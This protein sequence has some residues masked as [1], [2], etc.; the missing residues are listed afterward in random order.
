MRHNL[1]DP[2]HSLE[3]GT[4]LLEPP[5][6]RPD[7]SADP[8]RPPSPSQGGGGGPGRDGGGSGGGWGGGG[9]NGEP[10]RG[11]PISAGMLMMGFFL[12]A[13]TMLFAAF[14]AATMVYRATAPQWPPPGVPP[15]PRRLLVNT[16]VILLS[17]AALIAAA[18]A[19]RKS[20]GALRGWLGLT[21]FLG[22]LFIAL[23]ISI[24]KSLHGEGMIPQEANYNYSAIFFS[25]TLLHGLHLTGGLIA[26]AVLTLLA[27]RREPG[28]G[29]RQALGLCSVYWHFV[30]GLWVV[31]YAL[32]SGVL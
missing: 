2:L 3:S 31:L 4:G 1:M 20:R 8:A 13:V 25:M 10:Q 18:R 9:E 28:P 11:I 19:G 6:A 29:E 26:L 32:L 24:W 5:I 15:L 14:I 7:R 17:S 16:G 12:C 30:G 21:T 23:Q 27:L 22:L